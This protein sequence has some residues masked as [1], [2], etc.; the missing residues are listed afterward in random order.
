MK[1]KTR[2][3]VQNKGNLERCDGKYNDGSYLET[4]WFEEHYGDDWKD[5]ND[6]F[7]GKFSEF[8]NCTIV[9][10]IKNSIHP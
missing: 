10:L 4:K 7:S 5:W 3:I 9:F 6:C 1:T 2:G 8:N